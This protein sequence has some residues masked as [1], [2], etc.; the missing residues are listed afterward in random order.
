MEKTQVVS[1]LVVDPL[2]FSQDKFYDYI[3]S[4]LK[5][6]EMTCNQHDGYID[7][8]YQVLDIVN[9]DLLDNGQCWVRVTY[10]ASCFKPDIGKRVKTTV[11]MVFPHGIFSSLYVLRFLVPYKCLETKY[12][13]VE[14]VGYRHMKTGKVIAVGSE[15]TIQITNL[16]YDKGHFSCIAEIVE[17]EE[18]QEQE[19]HAQ[20]KEEKTE[21]S[22]ES[23]VV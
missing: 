2:Y 20:E 16:K 11:E 18:D 4:L 21:E 14:D 1:D 13:Y 15:I 5:E 17:E 12:V 3:L 10:E 23:V 19:K 22:I 9:Y 6:R 7:H 8:I